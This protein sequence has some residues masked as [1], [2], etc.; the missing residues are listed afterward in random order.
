MLSV[1]KEAC[2]TCVHRDRPVLIVGLHRFNNDVLANFIRA[3]TPATCYVITCL[4]EITLRDE[5][6]QAP[7]LLI[8]IDCQGLPDSE[9][10]QLIQTDA[11]HLLHDNIIALFNLPQTSA[12]IYELLRLGVRGFFFENDRSEILPKGIC[13][14]KRGELWMAREMMMKY[15]QHQPQ[16]R[17]AEKGCNNLTRRERDILILLSAGKTNEAIGSS[18]FISPHTVKTHLYNALKKIGVQNRL[19]AALWAAKYLL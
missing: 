2:A 17:P 6:L 7:W 10:L 18:L 5:L 15:I 1:V 13:T 4:R 11:G 19:Q 3:R 14:L 8:F 16:E 9:I 12:F